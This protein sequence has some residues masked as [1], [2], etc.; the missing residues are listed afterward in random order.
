MNP[1]RALRYSVSAMRR[2]SCD[3]P[4]VSKGRQHHQEK[5]VTVRKLVACTAVLAM[6]GLTTI[7]AEAADLKVTIND[8]CKT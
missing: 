1:R 8:R 2:R 3:G 6:F 4:V 5:T 7:A